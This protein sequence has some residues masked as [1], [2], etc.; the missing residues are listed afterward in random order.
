MSDCRS[1]AA[2]E[3]A[4]P[5]GGFCK[6][7]SR[8]GASRTRTALEVLSEDRAESMRCCTWLSSVDKR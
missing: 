8:S 1:V 6:A 3:S 7:R 5:E 4:D 2:E